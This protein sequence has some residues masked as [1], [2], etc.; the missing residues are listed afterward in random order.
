VKMGEPSLERL[1]VLSAEAPHRTGGQH[2]QGNRHAGSA[3]GHVAQLGGVIR[4]LVHAHHGEIHDHDLGDRLVADEAGADRGPDNGLFRDRRS[5]HALPPKPR[6]QS[7][8]RFHDSAGDDQ[9]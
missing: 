2:A 1:T 3:A 4:D 9:R 6:R 7:G 8:G 5:A